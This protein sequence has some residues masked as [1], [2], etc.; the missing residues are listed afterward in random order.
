MA[1]I[2]A[3]KQA[4]V[5]ARQELQDIINTQ[6]TQITLSTG[7]VVNIPSIH[8]DAQ[9]KIDDIILHHDIISKKVKDGSEAITAATT[10]NAQGYMMYKEW[11]LSD[12]YQ[13][14]E[15]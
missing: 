11:F 10:K 1:S 13:D 6:K 3:P 14:V 2:K 4:T 12:D 7:R 5:E 9:N 8:F 15:Y